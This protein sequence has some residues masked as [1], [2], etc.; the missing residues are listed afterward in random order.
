MGQCVWVLYQSA[1]NQPRKPYPARILYRDD[2]FSWV[3]FWEDG[4]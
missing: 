3:Q 2:E 1:S 4:K